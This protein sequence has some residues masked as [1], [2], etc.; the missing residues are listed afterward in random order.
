MELDGRFA[1]WAMSG[2]G[3][4]SSPPSEQGNR[5]DQKLVNDVTSLH[6]EDIE[7]QLGAEMGPTL[8]GW[9][10]Q[11]LAQTAAP[12]DGAILGLDFIGHVVWRLEFSRAS[13][14]SIVFPSLDASASADAYLTVKIAAATTRFEP[15]DTVGGAESPP[16]D[17]THA[18]RPIMRSD[19]RLQIEGLDCSKVGSVNTLTATMTGRRQSTSNL[20]FTVAAASAT[21]FH[22]WQRNRLDPGESLPKG[23]KAGTLELLSPTLQT[24]LVTLRLGGLGVVSVAAV[25]ND[26]DVESI[27]QARVELFCT[28]P[29]FGLVLLRHSICGAPPR[30]RRPQHEACGLQVRDQ[31]VGSD[32]RIMSSA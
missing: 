31:A 3:R 18:L 12:R 7:I 16:P 17:A 11:T 5:R 9:L 23:D 1:G 32:P 25:P 19:F 6:S 30:R 14:S 22:D 2:K 15:V 4:I 28:D 8:Y 13:V 21:A 27:R 10:G 20:S 29:G 24:A 26:T